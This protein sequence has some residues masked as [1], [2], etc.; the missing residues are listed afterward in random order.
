M[1]ACFDSARILTNEKLVGSTQVL[2]ATTG[3][4]DGP[5]LD[6]VRYMGERATTHSLILR[7]ETHTRRKMATEHLQDER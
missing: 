6:G 1:F 7:G 4:T 5:L 3:I 2:F